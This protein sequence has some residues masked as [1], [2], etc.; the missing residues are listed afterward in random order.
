MVPEDVPAGPLLVDTDVFSFILGKR[1]R[2][3]EFE[4]LVAGHLLALSFATVGELRAGAVK[5]GWGAIR[6]GALDERIR[7]TIVLRST[8][9]VI[10]RY[11]QIQARFGGRLKGGGQN[12]MWI[13]ACALAQPEQPP[14]VTHNLS[15]F[16]QIAREFPIRLVHPDL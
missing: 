5:A 9:D 10:D 4:E 16:S 11:G 7:A 13:A 2:F 12:D 6:I 14:I 15:D 8:D 1:G 3:D